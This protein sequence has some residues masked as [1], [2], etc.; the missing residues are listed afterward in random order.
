VRAALLL[1]SVALIAAAVHVLETAR[2]GVAMSETAVGPTPV[3]LYDGDGPTVVIAHGFAGSRQM[4]QGYALPLAQAGYRV[5]AFDFEGHG[6]HPAP[7]SGDVNVIDGTT[8]LLVDQTL[9][10]VEAAAA[11]EPV[12]LLGH[13]MATDILIRAAIEAPE[14]IGPLVVIS[15]F[16]QAV[17]ETNPPDM[18]MITGAWE[19]GLLAFAQKAEA[20]A[21]DGVARRAITA[22]L[23]EHVGVLHSVAGRA[24]A[25][26][27]LNGYY[28]RDETPEILH[29]GP[30]TLVLLVALVLIA[31][32]LSRWLPMEPDQERD[33][34][35]ALRFAGLLIVPAVLAPPLAV[36]FDPH[37][38]PVLVADHLAV[39][40]GLYGLIQLAMLRFWGVPFGRPGW[41]GLVAVLIWGLA[42]FGFA[43]DRYAANFW[44]VAERLPILAAL[45]LGAVPFMLADALVTDGGRASLLRRVLARV[46]FLGSLGFAVALDFEGLFFLIMIAP[47]IV[48]FYALYGL[49]GRWIAQ[50]QGAL[51]AGVGLGMCL[52]WALGVS[53]PMFAAGVGG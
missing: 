8:R 34:L 18:L 26:D 1:L 6:R 29:T 48:L 24:A 52:A 19:P 13:S 50:R 46:A 14:R 28:Q 11:T 22:P 42:L 37:A 30:W 35:S 23:A 49:V 32:P 51:A 25:V 43:L 33:P 31:W 44:P 40:L 38:L 20:M 7:M 21:A 39:H 4:M 27:W 47:V 12:A 2:A 15:A 9:S 16:S 36:L 53:F 5:M 17:D 10:I 45:A 41:A 3:T